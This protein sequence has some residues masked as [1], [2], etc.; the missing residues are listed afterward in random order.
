MS[1]RGSEVAKTDAETRPRLGKKTYRSS[2]TVLGSM[3]L[4]GHQILV[5]LTAHDPFSPGPF[6]AVAFG[7][8]TAGREGHFLERKLRRAVRVKQTVGFLI[9]VRELRVTKACERRQRADGAHQ[10]R[11]ALGEFLAGSRTRI[12]PGSLHIRRKGD[13]SEFRQHNR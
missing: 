10:R 11:I 6:M 7:A 2:M 5:A 3:V 13:S 1:G 12:A 4:D 8:R 9:S